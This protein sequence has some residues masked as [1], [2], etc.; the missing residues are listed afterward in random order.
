MGPVLREVGDERAYL[1]IGG[2][3][4]RDDPGFLERGAADRPDGRHDSLR[5]QRIHERLTLPT[6]MPFWHTPRTTTTGRP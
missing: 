2:N 6:V 5:V 1:G 4:A 3:D